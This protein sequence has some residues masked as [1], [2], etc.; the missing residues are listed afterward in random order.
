MENDLP[1]GI[2]TTEFTDGRVHK[3][4]YQYGQQ[5][6]YGILIYKDGSKYTGHFKD[7]K[8]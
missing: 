2:G 6:G 5:S 8:K 1:H 3:G 4:E 7:N